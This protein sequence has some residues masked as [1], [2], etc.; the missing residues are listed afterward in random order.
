MVQEMKEVVLKP[1]RQEQ[2][3]GSSLRSN[4]VLPTGSFE[5]GEFSKKDVVYHV[6]SRKMKKND[7]SK[8]MIHQDALPF[9]KLVDRV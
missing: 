1:D 8:H 7:F 3:F 4:F 2:N 5:V 9:K 6:L